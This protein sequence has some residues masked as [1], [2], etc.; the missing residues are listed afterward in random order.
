[1]PK[2][3]F[4]PLFAASRVVGWTAHVLEEYE[5][6]RLIRPTAQYVGPV[7]LQYVPVAERTG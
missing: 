5:D 4:T 3:L 7:D 1:M 2:D 6:L